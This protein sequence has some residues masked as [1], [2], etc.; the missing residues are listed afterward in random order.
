MDYKKV[1]RGRQ[2]RQRIM[3]FLSFIPDRYMIKVQ[4]RIKLGRFP[5]LNSPRRY[6]EKIQLYKMF[7]RN[8]IL[9]VLVD[10]YRVKKYLEEKGLGNILPELYGVYK[11]GEE[12]DFAGLPSRIVIKTNDGG[13]GDNVIICR[14]K[15]DLDLQDTVRKVNSWLDKKK[16]N[17]G[18]E[19][20][21]TQIP[22]SLIIVEEYLENPR[23]PELGI[24]DFKF[25][26][27]DGK[28][29]LVQQDGERFID[30]RRN[31]YDTEWNNV[32]LSSTECMNF[33]H[34]LPKPRNLDKM[35][36]LAGTLSEGLPAV[37][38]DL[39]SIGEKIYFGEMTFYPWSGYVQFIP[40]EFDYK[41]GDFFDISTFIKGGK[42][43]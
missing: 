27:F 19:W 36:E 24:D 21:Y 40:D 39:Y 7:Y 34:Q 30:H 8:P 15:A 31:F 10:K 6:T 17:A 42:R 12:I 16:S 1:F 9:P 23:N 32:R 26:C 14:D 18:R 5:D 13:G 37:R 22:E 2:T 25:F 28:P 11:R 43:L 20:A 35:L 33:E 29:M 4:Y 3:R 38:V 41:L